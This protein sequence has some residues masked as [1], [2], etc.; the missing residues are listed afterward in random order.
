M[1]V[2]IRPSRAEDG[3]PLAR[4]H[5][6][7]WTISYA[8]LA[9]PSWVVGRPFA[10]RAARWTRLAA[11]GGVPMWVAVVD[12]E[13]VGEVAAGASRDPDAPPGTGEVV[14]LYVDPDHQ[15]GGI[16][17]A[18]LARAVEELRAAGYV[19]ATLW[20]LATSEQSTAF[21]ARNGWRRDGAAK[22]ERGLGAPEVRYAREL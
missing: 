5:E 1:T 19:R 11:G 22:D 3:E 14:A 20:T 15:G 10:E 18:L 8:G 17:R 16:G 21:Y 6:R 7:C 12:G 2:E 9:D 13:V 4:V